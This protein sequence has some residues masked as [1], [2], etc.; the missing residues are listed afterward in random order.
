M[1]ERV[2]EDERRRTNYRDTVE[3]TVVSLLVSGMIPIRGQE[4]NVNR[5]GSSRLWA[6]QM[7]VVLFAREWKERNNKQ[8]FRAFTGISRVFSLLPFS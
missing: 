7:G 4:Q 2:R 6:S 1:K 8:R 5:V 3:S